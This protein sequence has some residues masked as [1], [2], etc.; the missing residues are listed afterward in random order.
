MYFYR[1]LSFKLF[2]LVFVVLII[3][4][5]GFSLYYIKTESEQYAEIARQCAYR[6][7]EV[8]A[9]SMRNS[10]LLNATESTNSIMKGIVQKEGIQKVTLF[11]KT[12]RIAYST[13]E[14]EIDR[15]ANFDDRECSPCHESSGELRKKPVEAWHHI[16]FDARGKRLMVYVRPI[17]NEPGCYTADC[18][19]HQQADS[20]LGLL[21]ISLSLEKMDTIVEQNRS[22]MISTNIAITL[23]LALTVGIM[24]WFF[25][26]VPVKRLILGTREVSNGNLSYQIKSTTGDEMGSL[27]RSF[28]RMTEDLREAK[29]EITS[30]SNQLENRVQEKTQE[31]ERTQKRNL[32]IEKMASL[33]QLSATVA[34]ELNNP[35]AG[36]LTYSKLI[37][38]KLTK[39]N[40]PV[41][42]KEA[43]LK[44]LKM[45]ETESER[46]GTI[47]KN[48]LLFSRQEAIEI[49][50]QDLNRVIDDSIDLIAHHLK[51]HNIK[52][53]REFQA[54]LP[55]IEIDDSQIKQALFALYINAVEA[56]ENEG[57]LTVKTEL[58]LSEQAV[59]IYVKDTGK[60][61]PDGLKAQI[62]EPF[63]T[64]KNAV[65]G[66][67]LGL[68]AVYAIVQ[69]HH[70][71]IWVE[72]EINTGSTFIVKIPVKQ[73]KAS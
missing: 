49:K 61:I 27:A 6:T 28:D 19:A 20:Y 32:Q 38:K 60:G 18:H 57:V 13:A 63:F 36:I 21:R 4:T 47:V 1:L 71:E 55:G 37:Q 34:H 11:D 53:V 48:M 70:G 62:F 65:K 24:I 30:W 66:V 58:K 46:S 73:L 67:G 9:G 10:M 40:T 56:M 69:R 16:F 44:Y 29:R 72:S 52:L 8:V 7:S 59:Y 42:E 3:L 2:V 14:E 64:T 51:L 35:I 17:A 54:D 15:I 5:V 12:G 22:R 26:H 43:I 68:S 31:L 41:P 39:D 45:I 23:A 33:G 25:V 50:A